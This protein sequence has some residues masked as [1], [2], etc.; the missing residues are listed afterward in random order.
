MD[1]GTWLRNRMAGELALTAPAP[2]VVKA[3]TYFQ[4]ALSISRGQQAKSWELRAAMSLA[5]LWRDQGEHNKARELLAPVYDW[6]KEGFQTQ[7]RAE[8]K[9]L[10]EGLDLH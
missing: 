5:R 2:D 4:R 8:A 9:A 3:E 1:I 6:F 10:L 7:D